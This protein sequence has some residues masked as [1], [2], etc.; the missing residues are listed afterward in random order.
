MNLTNDSL[1]NFLTSSSFLGVTRGI[2]I[3]TLVYPLEVVKIKQQCAL[4]SEKN[5]RI[6]SQLFQKEGLQAFYRGLTPQLI[7]T[8]IKQTWCWPLMTNMPHQLERY[9]FNTFYQ[10]ALTG[11]IIATFD[12]AVTSPL[13]RAKILS[14]VKTNSSFSLKT[15]YKEGW[16]GFT[17]QWMKL[18]V[19]WSVFLV[20]Q[21]YFREQYREKSDDQKLTF[22]QLIAS[23][24]QTGA[25]VSLMAAPFDVANT[26]KQSKNINASSLFS[27]NIV[28]NMYRGWPIQIL[29]VVIHNIASIMLLEKLAQL[30]QK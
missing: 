26:L 7:R 6:A 4:T 3:H 10:H 25:V 9:G 12:A 21:K 2:V 14:I 15:F 27:G 24:I 19:S 17:T 1:K 29:S 23:G 13:E 11:L 16:H 30:N 28:R 20:S 8:S 22:P 5:Y 18:A